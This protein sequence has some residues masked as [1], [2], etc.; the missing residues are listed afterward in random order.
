MKL[1]QFFRI[2]KFHYIFQAFATL[3]SFSAKITTRQNVFLKKTSAQKSH[4]TSSFLCLDSFLEAVKNCDFSFAKEINTKT[5]DGKFLN[6]FKVSYVSNETFFEN[7]HGFSETILKNNVPTLVV[8][9]HKRPIQ[10]PQK[11]YNTLVLN[12]LRE[13]HCAFNVQLRGFKTDRSVKAELQR[14]PPILTRLKNALGINHS[15]LQQDLKPALNSTNMEKLKKMLG[16]EESLT[17]S[18]KQRVKVA[19]AEGY[20]LGNNSNKG[21]KTQKYFKLFSQTITVIIFLAIIISLMAS[22][23][24]SVFR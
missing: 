21:S 4:K 9:N 10:I 1:C 13:N 24:G 20:L 14:N 7:K 15:N 8:Q 18:E 3:S 19:F 12:M 2:P 11:F 22:A 23:S 16:N 6:N 5:L 17:D